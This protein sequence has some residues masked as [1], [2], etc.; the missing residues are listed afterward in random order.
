MPGILNI[1]QRLRIYTG[2]TPADIQQ[3]VNADLAL[4]DAWFIDKVGINA[5][6]AGWLHG[7]CG[8]DGHER[9]HQTEES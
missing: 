5:V 7:S 6:G 4:T 9:E 8:N 1:E 3:A 2:N